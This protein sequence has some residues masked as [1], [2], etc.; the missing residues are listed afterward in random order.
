VTARQVGE[1]KMPLLNTLR[2]LFNFEPHYHYSKS[3]LIDVYREDID[4]HPK[5]WHSTSTPEM[6]REAKEMAERDSAK[7]NKAL[8]ARIARAYPNRVRGLDF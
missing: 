3:K 8:D 2:E 4:S 6:K 7:M 1:K 5:G